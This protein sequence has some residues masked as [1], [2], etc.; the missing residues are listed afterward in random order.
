M[1]KVSKIAG[2]AAPLMLANVDTDLIIRIER[3]TSVPRD[4]LGPYAFEALRYRDDGSDEPAFVLNQ[5]AFRNAPILLAGA[6]FGCGSSREGA[7][8]ALWAS[9]IRCVIAESFGDI[10]RNNCFQNGLLPVQLSAAELDVLSRDAAGGEYVAV[11]LEQQ[12]VSAPRGQTFRFEIEP[13]RRN[14]LLQGLDEIGQTMLRESDIAG[15]QQRDRES[16]PWM[17][18]PTPGLARTGGIA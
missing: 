4:Q 1:E 7:V 13:L 18:A 16:R 8:S 14:A 10:F 12:T 9:S 11:D 5:P 15:W 3:L 6:N 17:W 2:A